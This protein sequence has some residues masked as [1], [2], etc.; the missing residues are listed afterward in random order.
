MIKGEPY[1]LDPVGAEKWLLEAA[2]R[3]KKRPY[4]RLSRRE[5]LRALDLATHAALESQQ[6][7]NSDTLLEASY[8][9]LRPLFRRLQEPAIVMRCLEYM[10]AA[11]D[12]TV[13]PKDRLVMGDILRI[14]DKELN[15]SR[16]PNGQNRQVK[17]ALRRQR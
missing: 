17:Q 4:D 1:V 2:Q 13:Q 7:P 9:Y 6:H 14:M 3:L 16:R 10:R 12:E 5:L 11:A 15:F 8:G